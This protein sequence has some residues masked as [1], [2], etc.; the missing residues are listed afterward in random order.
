MWAAWAWIDVRLNSGTVFECFEFVYS[1]RHTESLLSGREQVELIV[2]NTDRINGE[3]VYKWAGKI[4]WMEVGVGA[5]VVGWGM[6]PMNAGTW[7]SE[8]GVHSD[9]GRIV[10]WCETNK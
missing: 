10:T 5:L 7:E 2:I 4:R 9:E 6:L 3:Q 8:N 1:G